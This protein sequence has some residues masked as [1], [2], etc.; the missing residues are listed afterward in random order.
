MNRYSK[1]SFSCYFLIF[2]MSAAM[3]IRYLM[4]SSIRAHHLEAIGVLSWDVVVPKFKI[5]LLMMMKGAGTGYLVTAFAIGAL[6]IPFSKGNTRARWALLAVCLTQLLG[7]YLNVQGLNSRVPVSAP[8]YLL[9]IAVALAVVAFVFSFLG[10]KV[11]HE[12]VRNDQ[13]SFTIITTVVCFAIVTIMSLVTGVLYTTADQV[14]SYHVAALGVADWSVVPS[15]YQVVLTTYIRGAGL[16]FLTTTVGLTGLILVYIKDN[17]IKNRFGLLLLSMAQLLPMIWI[18]LTVRLNTEGTPPIIP[19]VVATLL[20]LI[21]F[22]F[23][24]FFSGKPARS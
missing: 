8:T 19:V 11:L 13:K 12:T 6:L 9:F 10:E 17:D 18:V 16:G 5:M 7:R 23:P 3:G 4:A 21:G 20:A 15:G 24:T 1:I 22:V 2:L 14:M